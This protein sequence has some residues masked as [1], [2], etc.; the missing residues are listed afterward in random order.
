L[1]KNKI[2]AAYID[3]AVSQSSLNTSDKKNPGR[4]AKNGNGSASIY[5]AVKSVIT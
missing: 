2:G 4:L 3:K 1:A 5:K